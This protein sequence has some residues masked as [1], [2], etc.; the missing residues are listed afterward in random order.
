[1]RLLLVWLRA[2]FEALLGFFRRWAPAERD[3]ALGPYVTGVFRDRV[4]HR[5]IPFKIY[6]PRRALVPAPL[7]IFS[8]GLG[9]SRDSAPHLGRAL[10][11]N[12]YFAVFIQHPGSDESVLRGANTREDVRK[13]LQQ[14]VN[15]PEDALQRFRDIHVVLDR[16]EE[17]NLKGR[18]AG[19]LDLDRIG[20]AG[21][22]FGARSVLVAAG[23]QTGRVGSRLK[24]PRIRA[25]VA[26]SPNVPTRPGTPMTEEEL[27]GIYDSVDIPLLHITGSRDGLPLFDGSFDPSIRTLPFRA[28]R[29]PDQYLLVLDGA[30]HAT[31][32]RQLGDKDADPA[33]DAHRQAVI[34]AMVLF[35]DAY[36]KDD[37]RARRMLR[38][39]FRH[40]LAPGDV[41]EFK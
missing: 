29:G 39:G 27:A 25:G 31:F 17:M 15:R 21:H 16:I 37:A 9:A 22:S 8:H 23:Q 2:A 28:I 34:T 6:V 11:E 4:R 10:A 41:F 3:R 36:L 24:E 32:G 18:L 38:E 33:A 12:G 13:R 14:V 40:T 19:R 30:T 35:F 26:L 7:V 1:M 20:M 5:V